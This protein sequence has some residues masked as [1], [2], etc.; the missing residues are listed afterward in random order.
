MVYID[1]PDGRK[2]LSKAKRRLNQTLPRP[3]VAQI[4]RF[5]PRHRAASQRSIYVARWCVAS[6]GLED[7]AIQA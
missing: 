3:I 1:A 2:I 6:K 5:V 4:S 7:R